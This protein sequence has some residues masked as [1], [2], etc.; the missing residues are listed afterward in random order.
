MTVFDHDGDGV[1][2][3]RFFGGTQTQ[4]HVELEGIGEV[5]LI[6]PSRSSL[7]GARPG[8]STCRT[9]DPPRRLSRP[10]LD[11]GRPALPPFPIGRSP[12]LSDVKALLRGA[13]HN[14]ASPTRQSLRIVT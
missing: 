12:D 9:G 4:L 1:V 7:S 14:E 10:Y 11:G 13:S 6:A 2:R 3:K 5:I 8:P